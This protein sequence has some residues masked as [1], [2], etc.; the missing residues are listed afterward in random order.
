MA[1]LVVLNERGDEF[2]NERVGFEQL[3]DGR[4]SLQLLE[5]MVRAIEEAEMVF[6][7]AIW[8]LYR[9]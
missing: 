9:P 7:A 5:R 8:E 6:R 3:D 2:L 1:R 4:A